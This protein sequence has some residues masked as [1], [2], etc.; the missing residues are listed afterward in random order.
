MLALPQSAQA[1][2]PKRAVPDLR[3]SSGDAAAIRTHKRM[4][5]IPIV[6]HMA[7][8]EGFDVASNARVGQ[9][10]KRANEAFEPHGIEVYVQTVRRL[11]AGFS[12]VRRS[13]QRRSLAGFARHDG[14]VHLFVTQNL[15]LAKPRW[16]RR[17]VRGLHWR[18]RGI[19]RQLR[20]REY[21]VVTTQAPDT[22]LAHEVGHLLGL[23]H[24]TNED[25][26]MCSCRT[27]GVMGFSWGQGDS[28]RVGA[29]SYLSRHRQARRAFKRRADRRRR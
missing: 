15:D 2:G 22:T 25:N 12:D 29:S 3:Q 26:I 4:V 13:K 24:S 5:R 11:P 27:G 16:A 28:M 19:S 10:V 7:T 23:R 14:A 18:Y 20:H 1:R 9:W 21:V 8:Y 17:R 6:V